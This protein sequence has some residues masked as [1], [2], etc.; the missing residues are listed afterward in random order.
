VN[1]VVVDDA[2]IVVGSGPCGA[3]A[4]MRLVERGVRV[5]MLDAGLRAP[6]GE[7]VRVAGRT[8]WR[9]KGWAEYAEH[10]HDAATDEGVVW[11]SSLSLGGLSNYWTSAIPRYAPADFEDGARID[12]RFAWPLGYDDIEPYYDVLEPLMG[13]TAG[14]PIHGVPAGRV[15]HKV[16]LPRDWREVAGRASEHGHGVGVLP[17]ARGGAW[18]AVRRG[19]EFSS[20]HCMV[21]PLQSSSPATFVLKTGAYVTRLNWGSSSGRVESVDYVD[22]RS[23]E[24]V[25]MRGAAVVLAAGTIDSTVIVQR[26]TSPDFPEGLGNSHGLVGRYLH[27]HPREWW[28][29]ETGS[30]LTAL[31]HPVYIA[32]A[33][34]A[35]SDPMMATSLTLGIESLRGR[36]RTFYGG[37]ASALGVQ[38]L[39]TMIPSPDLGVTIGSWEGSRP[40]IHLRYEDDAVKN[41]T[42]A[43][44]RIREVLSCAGIDAR[45]PGPFQP[46][47]PGSSVHYGGTVRM[48]ADPEFG[49]LDRWNRMYDVPNVAV[50]DASCFPTGPEKNPTLTAMAL[51]ARAADRL[52]DDLTDQ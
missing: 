33:D 4:A 9:R 48:H 35:E 10:R 5:V 20:Y 7:F 31:A 36:L 6:K 45:V 46:L 19:T 17:M 44:E 28:T 42:A 23:G 25:R 47:A 16:R 34:H 49:V 27:D 38:V 21:A 1:E 24:R 13:L 12:E 14:D 43:R 15:R 11:I 18:M 39:G 30:P 37:R 3:A 51:A 41:I 22:R 26:S 32:R 2:V 50:V 8:L 29:V 52:A 40:T